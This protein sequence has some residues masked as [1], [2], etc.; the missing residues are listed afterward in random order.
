[1]HAEVSSLFGLCCIGRT[2]TNHCKLLCLCLSPQCSYLFYF[3]A[4][5]MCAY[6]HL[7]ANRSCMPSP[8]IPSP[9]DFSHTVPPPPFLSSSSSIALI[10]QLST[11]IHNPSHFSPPALTTST[12]VHGLY[13]Q[14][15]PCWLSLWSYSLTKRYRSLAPA[16]DPTFNFEKDSAVRSPRDSFVM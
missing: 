10:F 7:H 16:V 14:S 15:S 9:R 13:S 12:T 5:S 11:S 3:Y 8:I 4:G 6:I 2:A 1:M